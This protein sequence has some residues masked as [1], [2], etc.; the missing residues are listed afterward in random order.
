[1]ELGEIVALKQHVDSD[2]FQVPA[3]NDDIFRSELADRSCRLF[4]LL[5]RFDFMSGE[6]AGLVQIGRDDATWPKLASLQVTIS[7]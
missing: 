4:H 1:M 6:H 3:L 2:A 5:E 7:S